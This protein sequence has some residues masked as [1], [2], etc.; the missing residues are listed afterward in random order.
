M[1][2]EG[3]RG[4]Y[5]ETS[6]HLHPAPSHLDSALGRS[7]PGRGPASASAPGTAPRAVESAA[8]ALHAP[9][10]SQPRSARR[11]TRTP[12]TLCSQPLP[13][14][15]RTLPAG[16]ASRRLHGASPARS[17]S[18][19]LGEGPAAT[20]QR[21]PGE[22]LAV[23]LALE[24]PLSNAPVLLCCA[25]SGVFLM[26]LS[27]PTCSCGAGHPFTCAVCQGPVSGRSLD[28]PGACSGLGYDTPSRPAPCARA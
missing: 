18:R 24:S 19:A 16:S 20:A 3:E 8:S 11:L 2:G 25:R 10:G 27:L 6:V 23:T 15:L 5:K 1:R 17:R 26:N 14:P 12:G 13:A 9:G 7:A 21:A 28:P 4:Y 22:L